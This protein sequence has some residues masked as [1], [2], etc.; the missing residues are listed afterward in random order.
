[1]QL[2][3]YSQLVGWLKVLLP[4]LALAILSTL[5]LLS[6]AI[7]FKILLQTSSEELLAG[8]EDAKRL[9]NPKNWIEGVE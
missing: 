3:R 8:L 4:L 5:F 1:M 6:R 7:D 2:D 9:E